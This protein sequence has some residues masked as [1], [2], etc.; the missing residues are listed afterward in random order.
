[1]AV[2]IT[3]K[4]QA[5]IGRN[6]AGLKSTIDIPAASKRAIQSFVNSIVEKYRENAEEWCKQNAPWADKTGGA[7]AG[8]IGETIDSDNKIGFE[9]LHTVEYGT[10]LETANDGKYAV[11]FPCIRHFFPQFM[12]DAQKYFSGKY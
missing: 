1:M 11:L 7:R 9:V 2:K 4:M 10:Y 5:V 6:S 3:K 12:N 8:L